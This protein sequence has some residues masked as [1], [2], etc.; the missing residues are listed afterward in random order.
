MGS[1]DCRSGHRMVRH[2]FRTAQRPAHLTFQGTSMSTS[3][4]DTSSSC[5]T[6]GRATRS[7]CLV[8]GV[9]PPSEVIDHITIRVF[10]WR[11]HRSCIGR[12]SVQGMSSNPNRCR[13]RSVMITYRSG[14]SQ[15]TTRNRS[16]LL[17]DSTNGRTRSG[18]N[19][20]PAISKLSAPQSQSISLEYGAPP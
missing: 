7:V 3:V 11:L 14:C 2:P 20:Q 12:I 9:F 6:T 1:Q 5:R 10:P 8:G 15:G 13:S 18:V 4:L 19:L 17:I 16:L